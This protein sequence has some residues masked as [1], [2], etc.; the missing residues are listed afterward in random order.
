MKSFRQYILEEFNEY[1]ITDLTVKYICMPN[2]EYIKFH[3]PE[4]YSEDNFLIY[5]QDKYLNDLPASNNTME[6]YFGKNYKY[7]YDVLF[8]YDRYEKGVPSG[9][10]VEWDSNIDNTHNP[11]NEPFTY[12]NVRGLKYV[13][14]F[15]EFILNSESSDNIM[16]SLLKIFKTQIESGNDKFPLKLKLDDKNIT[17]TE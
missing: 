9:T 2:Q 7:I 5:I 10:C 4:S 6:K 15:D 13:I 16:D 17:Y 8:E 1:K 11:E 14:K 3:V 12:V